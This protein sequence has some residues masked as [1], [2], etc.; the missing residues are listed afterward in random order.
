[1]Y[2]VKVNF[3]SFSCSRDTIVKP[4]LILPEGFPVEETKS[5]LVCPVDFNEDS[6]FVWE[7]LLP[8][9]IVPDSGRAYLNL[10]GDV[11]GPALDNLDNLVQLPRGCGEQNMI[12]LVPNIHV[13][14]YLDAIGVDNPSLRAEATK[15]MEKG[16]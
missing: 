12:L 4:I 5:M 11:L 14:T 7:L 3:E 16:R 13:I 8:E 6:K 2:K 15:N 9:D 10:I 1:M